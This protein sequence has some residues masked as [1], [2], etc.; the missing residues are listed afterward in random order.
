MQKPPGGDTNW[1]TEQTGGEAVMTN[2]MF[3]LQIHPC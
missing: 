2:T 1:E 3:S